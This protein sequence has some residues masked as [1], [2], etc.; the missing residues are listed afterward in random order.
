MDDIKLL[1][2][3]LLSAATPVTPGRGRVLL[4]DF[5]LAMGLWQLKLLN[6]FIFQ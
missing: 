2:L 5:E 4:R 6:I 1:L 3:L